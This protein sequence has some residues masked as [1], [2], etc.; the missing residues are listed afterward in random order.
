MDGPLSEKPIIEVGSAYARLK[1]GDVS[2]LKETL[3]PLDPKRYYNRA[4]KEKRWDGRVEL[5]SGRSFPAGLVKFVTD[6]LTREKQAFEVVQESKLVEFDMSKWS[7]DI[8]PGITL[9][10]HQE[11]VCRV[12]LGVARGVG[13]SP[14][15]SGKTEIMAAIAK[16]AYEQ[17][18]WRTLI[19][20]SKKGL[21]KQSAARFRKYYGKDISVGQCGDGQKTIG[22][23]TVGTAQTLMQFQS[24]HVQGRGR[25]EA[26]EELVELIENVDMLF[27]DE[28]HHTS[29]DSWYEIALAAKNAKRRYGVSGT[30][31]KDSEVQDMKLMGATGPVVVDISPEVLIKLGLA[32]RPKICM[33]MS[34]NA[35]GE[36]LSEIWITTNK[37]KRKKVPMPYPDAYVAGVVENAS[38]NESVARAVAWLTD[39]GRRT[40]VICRRKEHFRLLEAQLTKKGI[41]FGSAWG[42]TETEE[43][44]RL[45]NLL[46]D[47]KLLCILATT[48]FDEGEDVPAVDAIVLAEGVKANTNAIQRIGRGMR[49]KKGANDLWVVDFV[50]TCHPILTKHGQ[51]R[52]ESYEG[53]GYEVALLEDWPERG[54]QTPD[55]LLPFETWETLYATSTS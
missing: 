19:V 41:D 28:A 33:V 32:A 54:D 3:R 50:P 4:Y 15:G 27:F 13:K 52:C 29:S 51:A 38:H 40:L 22:A 26:N 36:E 1:R 49:K 14:T 46:N 43:R 20:T 16:F 24:R 21:A 8:L 44:D 42:A 25:V 2:I 31:L 18:Q 17:F 34:D 47:N 6:Y 35:S 53:E 39:R 10:A 23:V 37:G 45:K 12:L 55:D 7:N 48:I 5:Y 9:W 30:P 11:E